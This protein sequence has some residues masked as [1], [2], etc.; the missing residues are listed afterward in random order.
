VSSQQY[1]IGETCIF[2][3]AVFE[4]PV[5]ILSCNPVPFWKVPPL[6]GSGE[7][8]GVCTSPSQWRQVSRVPPNQENTS[9]IVSQVIR[10]MTTT[11]QT[12][13]P[14]QAPLPLFP[15]NQHFTINVSIDSLTRHSISLSH[16]H[17]PCETHTPFIITA[18]LFQDL[19]TRLCV[20]LILKTLR[21][22]N[23]LC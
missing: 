13:S 14:Y 1:V 11:Q 22:K 3:E 10:A 12:H 16:T 2:P 15:P 20:Y 6:P 8:L 21:P 17:T 23:L 18:W 19:I 9:E 5:L 7:G 4:E